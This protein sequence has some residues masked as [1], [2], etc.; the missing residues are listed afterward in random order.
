MQKRA[1]YLTSN[2]P[3]RQM[4]SPCLCFALFGRGL[5][6]FTLSVPPYAF[7]GTVTDVYT[8]PE[9][10]GEDRSPS[11]VTTRASEGQ[12]A[13]RSDRVVSPPVSNR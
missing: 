12:G 3:V 5:T 9:R 8:Q 7:V 4:V 6:L 13:W 11:W 1:K 2:Q 10:I